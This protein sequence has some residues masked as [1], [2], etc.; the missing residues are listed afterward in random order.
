[1]GH[2]TLY[3]EPTQVLRNRL[4]SMGANA[5]TKRALVSSYLPSG[6]DP[7]APYLSRLSARSALYT[8]LQLLLD[9]RGGP[10]LPADYRKLILQQNCLARPSDSSRLKLWKELKNRYILNR[11]DPLFHA[12]WQEWRRCSSE[13]ERGLVTYIFLALNDRLVMDL[14]LSWLF[15]YLRKAQWNCAW[16]TF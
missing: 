13:A 10:L 6:L 1:L 9:D 8:D 12:F 4:S 2:S 14:G 5:N 11:E 15:S 7:H 16:M 3:E